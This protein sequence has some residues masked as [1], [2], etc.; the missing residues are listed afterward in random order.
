MKRMN[1]AVQHL[2]GTYN[3]SAFCRVV[4]ETE[5]RVCSVTD[6]SW[7]P[8]PEKLGNFDFVIRADRYLHG[9]VRAIVGTLIEVGQGKRDPNSIKELILSQ[10]RTLAGFAAPPHGLSLEKVVYESEEE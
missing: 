6:A 7:S 1:E 2:K 3:F 4:S 8:C 9:M 10:D 5:N